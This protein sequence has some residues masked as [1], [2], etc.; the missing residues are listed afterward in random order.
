MN[1]RSKSEQRTEVHRV[2]SLGDTELYGR[3]I[4]L[5]LNLFL[6]KNFKFVSKADNV[7]V[8]EIAL[9]AKE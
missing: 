1:L 6:E 4:E 3:N 7:N 9:F 5:I 2:W 8:T